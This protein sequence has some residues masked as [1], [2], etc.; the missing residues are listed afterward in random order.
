MLLLNN[1]S[2]LVKFCQICI[3]FY[4][5]I[6]NN[7][8]EDINTLSSGWYFMGEGN[9]GSGGSGYTGGQPQGGT[10]G[11]GPSGGG[12]SGGGPSGDS[13][14]VYSNDHKRV[15]DREDVMI[16]LKQM[17][18][19]ALHKEEKGFSSMNEDEKKLLLKKKMRSLLLENTNGLIEDDKLSVKAQDLPEYRGLYDKVHWWLNKK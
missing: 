16:E 6:F 10:S 5:L 2:L 19:E 1:P 18:E 12:P 11:G 14:I 3:F 8:I 17:A 4:K 7:S 9:S 15:Q 13:N